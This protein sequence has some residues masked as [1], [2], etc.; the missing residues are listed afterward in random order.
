[1]K[2]TFVWKDLFA[3]YFWIFNTT[4]LLIAYLG[5]LPF[6][7]PQIISDTFAGQL[8]L[9]FLL[10]LI[11][12]V[13]VPTTS[14]LIGISKVRN[15]VSLDAESPTNKRS[16]SLIHLFYGV[17][18]PLLLVCM[19]R[20]FW[21]RQLTP[22]STLLLIAGCVCIGTYFY[23]LINKH[24]LTNKSAW[25]QLACHSLMLAIA[26]YVGTLTLFY[27]IPIPWAILRGFLTTPLETL[28]S[29]ALYLLYFLVFAV[30]L[31]PIG[32]VIIAIATAPFG[33]AVL[34]IQA[35]RK[36]LQQFASRYGWT[37]AW[38]GTIAVLLTWLTLLIALQ[39]QPQNRA[40][41]LL[42]KPAQTEGDRTFLL[43]HSDIIRQELLN[44]YLAPYR[45]L[46]Y[47]QEN[48]NIRNLYASVFQLSEPALQALQSTYNVLI[49]PFL[50]NGTRLDGDKAAK[51]YADFFDTPILK[52]E[53]K[54]IQQAVQSTSN[55]AE[56]KAGLL[57]IN[58]RKVWLAKQQVNIESHGD[59][60]NVELY[61]VYEN[62]TLDQQEIVYS[63]SLPQSAVITG[64]WLGETA[65]RAERYP[66]TISPR[67]AAQ[68][69][70][71]QEVTR[72]VDPA[73]LE[74]VAPGSYR[75]RA[76]PVPAEPGKQLHLWMTYQ[77]MQQSGV[78]LPQL[79]EKRNIFWTN[80]TKR[81]HNG[82]AFNDAA[83]TWFPVVIPATVAT[84][85]KLHQINLDGYQITAKPLSNQD[86]RLPQNKHFALVLDT[87]RSMSA[88][89]QET[90][91]TL[92]W[93]KD[94]VVAD[95][96]FDLYVTA[97]P[98]IKPSRID[99]LSGFNVAN[100]TFYGTIQPLEILR[101]FE[102]LR[103]NTA[104]D[105][106]LL[107]TDR[108]SY[109]LADDTTGPV[110][111]APL[112]MVHLGGLQVAYDDGTFAA[113]QA[114]GGGVATQIQEV[115]QRFATQSA[116]EPSVIS[117]SDGYGW[118]LT[119]ND[120]QLTTDDE[121]SAFAAR[122]LVSHLSQER[123]LNQI[124]NLD[125]IHAIAKHSEIVTPYSS[126]IVLVNQRQKYAL[127]Q[128]EKQSDR[129]KREIED[130]QL[131]I[132]SSFAVS[133]VPE[134]AEWMLIVIVAIALSLIAVKN[135]V[136]STFD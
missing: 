63:F 74:Q 54:A 121:F 7:T 117:V 58:E 60:A 100:T 27:V 52:A 115:L 79:S 94:R 34:Y 26:L 118:F 70:Y 123:D 86:Y 68:A 91:Q 88:H 17:E 69:V 104:Y 95:N 18:A 33:M 29:V 85:P 3:I 71:T 101:Q 78:P 24:S 89:T 96:D 111:S 9:D 6:I 90:I 84:E 73:L 10:P 64:V 23:Q 106:I 51:L 15:T 57:D 119:K 126:M 120:K 97:S 103:G 72:R 136:F 82:K 127:Q 133:A 25:L 50:Y 55:R 76:F 122:Q 99:D 14:S 37:K 87:S 109:E 124:K 114:S 98:G 125:A 92:G 46:G 49:S 132:P 20:F 22:A 62:Q 75:L 36:K 67:G 53:Q 107:I 47:R 42:Q 41:S 112:W 13:G 8:P 1:M 38:V 110:M 44:A 2:K 31:S 135:Q 11:G 108:G 66:F 102:S 21:L 83:D 48:N 65:N 131:P 4:L 19:I 40:F 5:I 129:F 28:V 30:I 12:L 77:A 81:L 130:K 80:K 16:I 45:Y 128:A 59:W 134:P 43:Q 105:A 116:L 32:V 113:I 39:Q 61:E 93:L 35:W 56:A